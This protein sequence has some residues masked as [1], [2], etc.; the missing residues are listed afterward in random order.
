MNDYELYQQDQERMRLR[1]QQFGMPP[2]MGNMPMQTHDYMR[3]NQQFGDQRYYEFPN[4]RMNSPTQ[5]Q[6][7]QMSIQ[8]N[9]NNAPVE[10]KKVFQ[11]ERKK[12][13]NE[14]NIYNL[15]RR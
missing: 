11:R 1:Q 7:P 13:N 3:M 5:N 10:E 8:N 2:Q 6:R 15:E 14:L 12:E 9:N 4:Q